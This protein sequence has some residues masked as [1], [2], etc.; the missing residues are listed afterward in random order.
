MVAS[1]L[2][3]L[4]QSDPALWV[5]CD[6]G[7]RLASLALLAAIPTARKTAFRFEKLAMP[8][9]DAL[10]WVLG[11][12]AYELF[13]CE[14][15]GKVF[16]VWGEAA[17][18]GHYP[19]LTGGLHLLDASFGLLLVA[20]HE[21]VIFRR[22]TLSVLTKDAPLGFWSGLGVTLGS[23]LLFGAYH[24]WSGMANVIAATLFG[25]LAMAVYR[26]TRALWPLVLAHYLTDLTIFF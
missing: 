19:D 22:C 1:Q 24:W 6:Y 8:L 23:A 25:L 12:T 10:M 4:H 11:L 3:R 18:L 15:F 5:A 17:K 20:F 7:G 16:D 9:P 14:N 2:I 26:R 21:E 13:F